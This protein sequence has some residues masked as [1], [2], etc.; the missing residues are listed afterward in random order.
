LPENEIVALSPNGSS[1]RVASFVERAT[2]MKHIEIAAAAKP[3]TQWVFTNSAHTDP[4]RSAYRMNIAPREVFGQSFPSTAFQDAEEPSRWA[5][6][7]EYVW[8]PRSDKEYL[9]AMHL[10]C[11]LQYGCT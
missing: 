2:E 4:R 8:H 5:N 1:D 9:K 11:A 10:C 7:P 3:A 6:D